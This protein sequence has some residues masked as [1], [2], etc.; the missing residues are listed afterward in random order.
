MT[1]ATY[2]YFPEVRCKE[3]AGGLLPDGVTAEVVGTDGN[4]QFLQLTKSMINYFNDMTYIPV[5]IVHIDRG[6]RTV[7]IELPT[8]ADSGAN[9]M[10][11]RF[12]D[13]R[14]ERSPTSTEAVA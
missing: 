6:N 14:S 5:G 1:T 10:W 12:E 9:R 11:V 7:L 2:T 8:E 4:P 3:T 13:L